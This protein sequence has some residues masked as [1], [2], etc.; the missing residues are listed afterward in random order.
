V[1]RET[2][3]LLVALVGLLAGLFISLVRTSYGDSVGGG[4]GCAGS[5]SG[6]PILVV[7]TL[8]EPQCAEWSAAMDTVE[9]G[10]IV[11][12]AALGASLMLLTVRGR[13]SE[14]LLAKLREILPSSKP[15]KRLARLLNAGAVI[16]ILV[17]ASV[18]I[19]TLF[20]VTSSA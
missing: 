5:V 17:G 15:G 3:S 18:L 13:R 14:Q 2:I 7:L 1:R 12:T 19:G 11:T 16:T 8:R 20:I 4:Y 6:P 10:A 9:E